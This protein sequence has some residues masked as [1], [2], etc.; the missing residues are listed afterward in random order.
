MNGTDDRQ[1]LAAW[2][3]SPRKICFREVFLLFGSISSTTG[4]SCSSGTSVSPFPLRDSWCLLCSLAHSSALYAWNVSL[5]GL[6]VFARRSVQSSGQLANTCPAT[7]NFICCV[8]VSFLLIFG[9]TSVV[10]LDSDQATTLRWGKEV[11]NF[12]CTISK[13]DIRSLQVSQKAWNWI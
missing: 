12:R 4:C 9:T 1:R 2:S 7:S 6:G 5:C 8:S 3:C 13:N 11:Q 10:H